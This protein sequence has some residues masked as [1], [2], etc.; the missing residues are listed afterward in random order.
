MAEREK[1]FLLD[2]LDELIA[3]R[4]RD[5]DGTDLYTT[6]ADDVEEVDL[7]MLTGSENHIYVKCVQLAVA[8]LRLALEGDKIMDNPRARSGK[9]AFRG[10]GTDDAS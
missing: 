7:A 5:P 1:Q 3:S 9:P 10:R 6:F 2:I 8:S 4:R